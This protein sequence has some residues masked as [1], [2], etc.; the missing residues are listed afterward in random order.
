M[1]TRSLIGLQLPDGTILAIYCHNDGQLSVNGR[2]LRDNYTTEEKVVDL[3]H[4]GNLSSLAATLED[5]FSYRRDGGLGDDQEAEFVENRQ[6]FIESGNLVDFLYL[7]RKDQWW[8]LS[9]G[10]HKNF[11]RMNEVVFELTSN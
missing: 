9:V 4:L 1:S 7:F 5:C 11:R 10:K 6:K 2:L 3:L 8:Y